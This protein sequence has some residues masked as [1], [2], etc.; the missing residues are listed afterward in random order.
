MKPPS[1]QGVAAEGDLSSKHD[2]LQA[3][4]QNEVDRAVK[5]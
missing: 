1:D 5:E 3:M 2:E 4:E